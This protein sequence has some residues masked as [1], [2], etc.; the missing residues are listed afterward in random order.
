MYDQTSEVRAGSLEAERPPLILD[1]L[2]VG[3][4]AWIVLLSTARYR[5]QPARTQQLIDAVNTTGTAQVA[6]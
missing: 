6:R 1:S 4:R 3:G 2:A 5:A